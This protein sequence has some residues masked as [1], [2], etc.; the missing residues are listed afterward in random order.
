MGCEVYNRK[1]G[2]LYTEQQFADAPLRFLYSNPAGKLLLN[3]LVCRPWF[4][5][6]LALPYYSRASVKKIMPFIQQFS[7][8]MSCYPQ[9]DYNSFNDFFTR[10]INP[11]ARPFPTPGH[12]LASPADAKLCV[13]PISDTMRLHIKGCSYSLAELL[14]NKNLAKKYTGGTCFVF[15]LTVDDYHRFAFIDGGKQLAQQSIRGKLHTVG[16]MSKG[17]YPVYAQN[18]RICTVMQT[19]NFKTVAQLDVGALL[20]GRVTEHC[21]T[22]FKRG[23]EKGF[24]SY[25][26]ST[27]IVCFE[28]DTVVPDEDISAFSHRGIEVKV[29]MGEAIGSSGEL[30]RKKEIHAGKINSALG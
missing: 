30:D 1:T 29:L 14:R 27:I 9:R 12:L 28:K 4:S 18:Q 8:D 20:V 26:G 25:G 2:Q 6:C 24:F 21:C 7:I 22:S 15:R 13:Y 19:Q 16:P 11:N 5:R 3:S 10:K 23:Q 17:K